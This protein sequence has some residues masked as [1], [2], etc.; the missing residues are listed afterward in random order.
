MALLNLGRVNIWFTAEGTDGDIGVFT[1]AWEL[2]SLVLVLCN[3][4]R[5]F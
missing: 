3:D 2:E 5:Q 1:R 4:V